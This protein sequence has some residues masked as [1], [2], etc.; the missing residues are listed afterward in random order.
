MQK[1]TVASA[2]V[3]AIPNDNIVPGYPDKVLQRMRL[4]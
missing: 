2:C 4:H 1:N 3:F